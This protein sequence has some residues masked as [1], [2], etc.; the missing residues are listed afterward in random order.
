MMI[1]VGDRWK[2]KRSVA[3]LA[4]CLTA[5][6]AGC[7]GDALPFGG[8]D[9]TGGAPAGGSGGSG[10]V[11]D[12]GGPDRIGGTG[13]GVVSPGTGGSSGTGGA[14]AGTG[15]GVVSPGTGGRSGSGGAS[16]GT[17]GGSVSPGTGGRSGSGGGVAPGTGGRSGSGGGV[18]PGTGGR[19]G[20]GGGVAPGTGGRSGSGG[21]PG[22]TGGTNGV[23]CQKLQNDYAAAMPAAKNCSLSLGNQCQQTVEPVL[24]CGCVTYVQNA[25]QLRAIAEQWRLGMCTANCPE[26]VCLM[27]G[28]GRCDMDIVLMRGTCFDQS[29]ATPG[30]GSP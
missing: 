8:E 22:G 12:A 27:P 16:A 15:G 28:S 5:L 13:G 7:G 26:V 19:S 10:A 20:S 1:F 30:T 11:V 3:C 25:D 2:N 9:G 21:A 29:V 6:A 17:G 14:P 18:A 24:G 23:D 4:L